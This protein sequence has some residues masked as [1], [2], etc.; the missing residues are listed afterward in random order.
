MS[1]IITYLNKTFLR[2]VFRTLKFGFQIDF[3][4]NVWSEIQNL[5]FRF[6]VKVCI[7]DKKNG[8]ITLLSKCRNVRH[9]LKT[10]RLETKQLFGWL[11]YILVWISNTY[12]LERKGQQSL[13]LIHRNKKNYTV[14]FLN[15]S[16]FP[17][18][19]VH[20]YLWHANG[21][22]SL[23]LVRELTARSTARL[24]KTNLL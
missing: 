23:S 21:D 7:E 9:H 6:E 1:E 16:V 5:F 8:Q 19:L 24:V 13:T 12:C 15:T 18:T 22:R 2:S 14:Y 17:S 20:V 4:A 10:E 11:K 3:K